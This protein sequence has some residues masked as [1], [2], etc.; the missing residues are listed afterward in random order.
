M[1]TAVRSEAPAIAVIVPNRNDSEH[2]P[3]CLGSLLDQIDQLDEILVVDDQS[4]DD[5]VTLIRALIADRPKARLVENPTN[6][7]T[8][9]ALNEGLKRVSSDYVLFLA[10]NDFVLPGIFAR[11]KACLAARPGLALW[12]AMAW[13]VDEEDR[14]IRLHPSAVLASRDAWFTPEE[15]RGLARRHGNWFT[16]PTMIYHRA[17]LA[18]VGGFDPAYKGLSD[19]VTALAVCARAGAA[20]SPEPLGAIRMHRDSF[21][22]RT[23]ADVG[24]MDGML[25]LLRKRG[26]ALA[27]DLFTPEF[28]ARTELRFRFAAVR[29]SGGVNARAVAERLTGMRQTAL[30]LI[31]QVP[32]RALR[33]GRIGAAFLVLR[34]FDLLPTL[35][36]RF[37]GWALVRMRSRAASLRGSTARG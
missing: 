5:S 36:S 14:P 16:G 23:L 32:G 3:R 15:C 28:L 4:T 35:S 10:A 8:N 11:A 9:G 33:W 20:F 18:E 17:L 31:G 21:L 25:A 24:W 2:L 30:R 1:T 6:L 19:L 29:A 12:S 13:L 34:P 7:G 27:P 22:S 26:P 37:L